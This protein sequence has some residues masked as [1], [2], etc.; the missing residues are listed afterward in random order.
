MTSVLLPSLAAVA[1]CGTLSA[2]L[3]S[4][5]GDVT[6][7]ANN[8]VYHILEESTWTD[9]QAAAVQLGGHLVTIDDLAED[10]WVFDTFGNWA[11]Q[12]RDMWIGFNDITAEGSFEWVSG[13]P[14]T[15]TNWAPGQPDNYLGNNATE[16]EDMV[17][18]Y[19]FGSIYGP[20]Q[21]NDMHDADPGTAGWTFG[22][23]GIVELEGPAFTVTNL[24][25]GAMAT[26]DIANASAFGGVFIGYSFT[27][28]GPTTTPFGVVDLSPP[29]RTG[30]FLTADGSGF[31]TIDVFIP[32]SLSGKTIYAQAVDIDSGKLTNSLAEVIL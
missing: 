12:P 13:D 10:T 31:A 21:W 9:A 14:I 17:H 19:G 8:H 32:A 29:I 5:M 26:L 30:P 22:L 27:G 25:G 23:Y 1:L 3:P 24:V 7:P 28:A 4:S 15:Y 16:G 2:Q 18:M 11:S 6:N 20:G